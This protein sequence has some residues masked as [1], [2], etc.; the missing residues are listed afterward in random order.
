MVVERRLRLFRFVWLSPLAS[1]CLALCL[2]LIA[3]P[4]LAWLFG[5]NTTDKQHPA[6]DIWSLGAIVFEVSSRQVPYDGKS[7]KQ[8]L[9]NFHVDKRPPD[10]SLL[11]PGTP[12]GVR[13]LI[14]DCCRAA[15]AHRPTAATV[16]RRVQALQPAAGDP[17][18]A[19]PP[20]SM[21]HHEDLK[22]VMR[23]I[24]KQAAALARVEGKVNATLA[25]IKQSLTAVLGLVNDDCRYPRTFLVLPKKRGGGGGGGGGV[26]ERM[27]GWF[28]TSDTFQVVFLCE[29]TLRHIKYGDK[30]GLEFT[31]LKEPIGK[32]AKSVAAVWKDYAPVLKLAAA[33]VTTAVSI[34]TGL[35]LDSL[36]PSSVL[37]IAEGF[38]SAEEVVREYCECL[39][40]LT[41]DNKGPWEQV[42]PSEGLGPIEECG[43]DLE[44]IAR[45]SYFQF[46]RFLESKNFDATKLL[47]NAKKVPGADGQV[48]WE[49]IP[50]SEGGGGG[51][52]GEAQDAARLLFEDDVRKKPHT[53]AMLW[54]M[55]WDERRIRLYRDCLRYGTMVNGEFVEKTGS[56]RSP[57]P[58]NSLVEYHMG[59]VQEETGRADIDV[60]FFSDPSWPSSSSSSSSS[61]LR[62]TET[63]RLSSAAQR[64]VFAEKLDLVKAE[65]TAAGGVSSPLQP[66]PSSPSSP[67]PRPPPPPPAAQVVEGSG[68]TGGG[69][70]KGTGGG[71]ERKRRT[72]A[73]KRPTPAPSQRSKA[74]VRQKLDDPPLELSLDESLEVLSCCVFLG[75]EQARKA[76]SA[77]AVAVIGNT[78][79]G[80]STFVN[81][82][83]G[84]ELESVAK[85]ALASS[86]ASAAASPSP[87]AA[88]AEDATNKTDNE[89][90]DQDDDDDDN[91]VETVIRVKVGEGLKPELM[92][93]GHSKK[94][95]TF[96]PDVAQGEDFA[97]LDCPGFL[98]NRGPEINIANAV[99]I[100]QA[101]HGA[102][103]VKVVVIINYYSIMVDRGRGQREL[104]KILRDLFGSADNI[105]R[106]AGSILLGVSQ[107]PEKKYNARTGKLSDVQLKHVRGQFSDTEGMDE[108]TATVVK[109]LAKSLF[110]YHPLDMGNESWLNRK[111]LTTTIQGMDG[112]ADP[113]RIFQSVLTF[114]DEA[115]LRKL[116][117][118][119]S[120]RLTAAMTKKRYEDA[121]AT[122]QQLMQLEVIGNVFV[123]RLIYEAT[124]K[125]ERFLSGLGQEA[126]GLLLLN[127]FD[128]GRRIVEELQAIEDFFSGDI[129]DI[130]GDIGE[131]MASA[132]AAK[133]ADERRMAELQET[134][135]N[136]E[137]ARIALE[138]QQKLLAEQQEAQRLEI[139]RLEQERR[140]GEAKARADKEKLE[141]TYALQLRRLEEQK[142]SASQ[143]DK[144]KLQEEMAK[145]QRD[146]DGK[147]QDAARQVRREGGPKKQIDVCVNV[148]EK[149]I[150]LV[151]PPLG[152]RTRQ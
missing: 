8:L 150:S 55:N 148:D 6:S 20:R 21:Q 138:L 61:S 118:E 134:L 92:P 97:F 3:P 47:E 101:L 14:L 110:V 117:D 30:D 10:V 22:E 82:L 119:L 41:K 70:G 128:D 53:R 93:I 114:E 7:Q 15:P 31:V 145:L 77:D 65:H 135:K 23:L 103:S 39:T 51:S 76:A 66:A 27:R 115:V 75:Q 12:A 111:Q 67:T 131:R 43:A 133:Q 132:L 2:S 29:T 38:V 54:F 46:Q 26:T 112:I 45:D 33:A 122:L 107:V 63:F 60:R 72:K 40:T 106:C 18:A 136:S 113:S 104:V 149:L 56:G 94:S 123:T 1:L 4:S 80:K 58:V 89:N 126:M 142:E 68:G 146:L 102:A 83:H 44:R 108:D 19:P 95:A 87:H 84:C 71:R 147:L 105:V 64:G 42:K 100:K 141:Q 139:E 49:V 9:M 88:A 11:E 28:E 52:R 140:T 79:A 50:R 109:L 35:K 86:A 129:S 98:D 74:L 73:P 69:G 99:N 25:A 130:A 32:A 13:D 152:T 36:L 85:V 120:N 34:T 137:D 127:R 24:K 5:K 37:D 57:L 124:Q 96:V 81:Y 116:V 143:E 17:S 78:G 48:H 121:A 91:E 59:S 16:A 151:V 144:A 90:D 125:T 62:A